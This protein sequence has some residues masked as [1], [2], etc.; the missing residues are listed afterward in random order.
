[1]NRIFRLIW[2]RSLGRLVVTSEGA[3]ASQKATGSSG[4]VGGSTLV[5]ASCHIV[6]N[7]FR[8]SPLVL[9]MV[10]AGGVVN[11]QTNVSAGN[12][13]VVTPDDE[14]NP[15]A[16]TVS[17]ED[18]VTFNNITT[19]GLAVSGTAILSALQVTGLTTLSGGLVM[20]N[21]QITG[22]AN[23]TASDHAVNFSQ[24]SAVS[25]AANAGWNISAGDGS[26]ENVAPGDSV[27]FSGDSNIN[28]SRTGANLTFS[29]ADEINVDRIT[30][31]SAAFGSNGLTITD[32]PSVTSA[33]IDAGGSTITNLG[34]GLIGEGSQDAVT[35][36]QV[37]TYF[38]EEGLGGGIRYF[39]ANSLLPDS[40]AE[41][42]DSVAIGPNTIT[43][44][45][46]SFA[47]G[48][49]AVT[50]V[51]GVGAIALG[52]EATAGSADP[53]GGG[54]G[55]IAVGRN[56]AA[57]A[58]SAVALG[59]DALAT[60]GNAMALGS[61]AQA[62]GVNGIALGQG[63]VAAARNNISIGEEAG[64]GTVGAVGNDQLNNI[65]IGA[66]SGQNVVGQRNIAMGSQ[67]G[68]ETE[69]NDNIA[70]GENAG[71]NL[72]SDSSISIGRNANSNGGQLDRSIAIGEEAGAGTDSIAV[73]HEASASGVN[74]VALGLRANTQGTGVGVGSNTV[75]HSGYV[76]LGTGAQAV[77]SDVSGGGAFT[78]R[79]FDGTAV[80]VGS[81][82]PGNAFTRRIV[83]V[84][85]GANETD[86]VNVR[87]LQAVV[88]SSLNG[89]PINYEELAEEVNTNWSQQIAAVEPNY[90]SINDGGASLGNRDNS[91][92]LATQS[93]AL[94]P[95]ASTTVEATNSTAIGSMVGAEGS[96]SVAL[97]HDVKAL[98]NN[99][100]VIGN[101]RTEA[102]DISG[103]AIGTSVQSRGDNSIVIGTN[104]ESDDQ[105][106]ADVVDNSIVIG[107]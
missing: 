11:A 77:Q 101:G 18:D 96:S 5:S 68:N 23:G 44:G 62:S 53:G 64:F 59:G 4:V 90:L 93:I 20:S 3:R 80:S 22:L 86:A 48:N 34:T 14:D 91:G 52:Q 58:D 41:G 38:V 21:S 37:F 99:T 83:N 10:M 85:D 71:S 106:S 51:D 61:G 94:G 39:R 30:A 98:S 29:L 81:S 69:G 13:I 2:N 107:T 63:A 17:T 8:F 24:L 60:A 55:A 95:D 74:G 79:A 57:S 28:V 35:G 103:V 92:A 15:T 89:G 6:R 45:E 104:S 54:A 42:V 26:S 82:A 32:G 72:A 7:A 27:D 56:S 49:D 88:D 65:A 50:T 31:G 102:R 47:A 66:K 67:A 87:Q 105:D 16:Y 100:T 40:S 19:S 33:G 78:G 73:G 9:A 46:S 12:N 1:M 75:A 43:E 70:F 97:G 25:D 84:E 76:A 36:G